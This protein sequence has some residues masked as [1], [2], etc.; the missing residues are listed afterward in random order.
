[1]HYAVKQRRLK[2]KD[3][4]G[5]SESEWKTEW[6]AKGRGGTMTFLSLLCWLS[7]TLPLRS[8]WGGIA[9]RKIQ[10][11]ASIPVIIIW[12]P[13]CW[14]CSSAPCPPSPTS[15]GNYLSAFAWHP[16]RLQPG[17][18]S[19]VRGAPLPRSTLSARVDECFFKPHVKYGTTFLIP[20]CACDNGHFP[21]GRKNR[22]G[23]KLINNNKKEF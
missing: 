5:W 1:M 2:E 8:W 14:I 4:W 18:S 12:I 3:T 9:L 10:P 20:A 11:G 22:W 13:D 17:C 16:L 15:M 21:K 19:S 23:K 7:P 6:K